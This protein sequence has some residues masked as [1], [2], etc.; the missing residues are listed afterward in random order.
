MA[1]AVDTRVVRMEFDNKQFEKNIKQTNQSL[2]NLKQNLDFDG[3][4][5]SIDK[6][7]LKISALQIVATTFVANIANRITNLAVNLIKSLSVDN[8]SAGWS[9]FGEKT[10]SVATML[11]QKIRIAGQEITD[12]AEKTAIVNE[13]LD[14]LNWFSDETS[15]SFTDMADNVGKFIAAGQDLDTSVKAME[16]IATWAAKAGQNSS[17]ASRAMYQLAQAM[18][19]GKIQKIDWMSIQNANMDTEEFRETILSTAVALGQLTKEGENYVTKTGKKFK[20]AQFADYLSEGWFT[21]E[22]LVKGL[23]KYSAAIDEIYTIATREGITASEVIEKYGDQLDQFGVAAFK[24]AQEAR[25]F[26]DVLNS[27]KDAVSSKWMTTFEYIFGSEAEAVKLWTDLANEL[28]D[29][30]AEGGNFRNDILDIWKELGGREDLFA[31]DGDNQGAFWNIY[32]AIIALKDLIK[33]AWDTVFPLS[34]MEEYSSQAEDIGRKFKGITKTIRE[35]TEEIKLSEE[36]SEKLSKIFQVIFNLLKTGLVMIKAIYY[37]VDPIIVLIK[38]L[39]NQVLNEAL[40]IIKKIESLTYDMESSLVFIRQA[41]IDILEGIDL[42]SAL[43]EVFDSLNKIFKLIIDYKPITRFVEHIKALVK[44]LN[45]TTDLKKDMQSF[46]TLLRNIFSFGSKVLIFVLSILFDILPLLSKLFN[47]ISSIAGYILGIASKLIGIVSDILNG[48]LEGIAFNDGFSKLKTTF[49]KIADTIDAYM[50]PIINAIT[51][52]FGFIYSF[53]KTVVTSLKT[54][55]KNIYEALKKYNIFEMLKKIFDSIVDVIKSFIDSSGK[56]VNKI[57]GGLSDAFKKLF[58]SIVSV[59]KGIIPIVTSLLNVLANL[60]KAIGSLLQKVGNALMNV[61]QGD[62]VETVI[63]IAAALGSLVVIFVFIYNFVWALK[64]LIHPI[65]TMTESI[66]DTFDALARKLN[67]SIIRELANSIIKIAIALALIGSIKVTSLFKALFAIVAITGLIIAVMFAL[68]ELVQP[69]KKLEKTSKTIKEGIVNI[70]DDFRQAKSITNSTSTLTG[71]VKGIQSFANSI[72]KIAI[73]LRLIKDVPAENLATAAGVI[74]LILAAFVAIMLASSKIKDP[75]SIAKVASS[76]SQFVKLSLTFIGIATAIKILSTI[77]WNM[78]LITVGTVVGAI[79]ILYSFFKIM[80]LIFRKKHIDDVVK[81]TAE[82]KKKWYQ[83]AV[84]I[85][86]IALSAILIASSIMILSTALMSFAVVQWES[87]WKAL[88]AIS[89]L[90]VLFSGVVVLISIVSKSSSLKEL[91]M[92]MLAISGAAILL[93]ASIAILATAF[94]AFAIVQWDAMWM[95]M[96]AISILLLIF[97]GIMVLMS[98]I[99]KLNTENLGKT[100]L[101][102]AGSIALMAVSMIILAGAMALF[103]LIEWGSI[104]KALTAISIVS[105]LMVALSLSAAAVAKVNG[106]K[107]LFILMAALALISGILVALA[108]IIPKFNDIE[109]DP[110]KK[111]AVSI[112]ILASMMVVLALLAVLVKKLNI[113]NELKVI[114]AVSVAIMASLIVLSAMVKSF[115]SIEWDTIWKAAISISIL[116][117][118]FTSIIVLAAIIKKLGAIKDLFMTIVALIAFSGAIIIFAYALNT[119]A[120]VKMPSIGKDLLLVAAGF[121]VLLAIA[122]LIPGFAKALL[123]ISASL[124]LTGVGL[125]TIAYG[126][127]A[128]VNSI[129]TVSNMTEMIDSLTALF[130]SLAVLLVE[131]LVAALEVLL[132]KIVELVPKIISLVEKVL[133]SVITL[134][135]EKGPSIIETAFNIIDKFLVEFNKHA[136]SIFANIFSIIMKY[137]DEYNKNIKPLVNK[138]V[139]ILLNILNELKPRI[140][141]IVDALFNVLKEII[142]SVF[143]NTG[144][145][146]QTVADELYK[147]IA[148]VLVVIVEKTVAIAGLVAKV[149]LI[150]LAAAIRITIASLGALGELFIV[151]ISG[152]LLM[153]VNIVSGLHD[154]LLEVFKVIVKEA[155]TALVKTIKTF[156]DIFK[157]VGKLVLKLLLQGL[158]DALMAIGGW[159]IDLWDKVFGTNLR[160]DIEKAADDLGKEAED[161]VNGLSGSVKD[162]Q[163][164]INNASTNIAE[165]VSMTSDSATKAVHNGLDAID[166]AIT[167]TVKDLGDTLYKES[168]NAGENITDGLEDG[169]DKKKLEE[170]IGEKGIADPVTTGT[171]KGLK[172]NSPSKVFKA[173]GE[174]LMDGLALGIKEK[175]DEPADAMSSVIKDSISLANDIIE[176]QNGTDL[177]LTVGMDISGVEAQSSKIKDIMSSINDPSV[178]PAGINADY[179]SAKINKNNRDKGYDSGSQI[180]NSND[181]TYNNTFNIT[182]TDPQQSAE[183]ID[184]MLQR[185]AQMKKLAHGN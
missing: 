145:L 123:L 11:A 69:V 147:F 113:L 85:L 30:F 167:D 14:L 159:F 181:V 83:T 71:V 148:K 101:S 127:T 184:K 150:L 102:V 31:R 55:L 174:F 35:F 87:I 4:G 80:A 119:L 43:S 120:N 41:I 40:Y 91:S 19:K 29:V 49:Q 158:I 136:D 16:G 57:S 103:A 106:Q 165:V 99:I 52:A 131:S 130:K 104:W 75:K 96:T 2:N 17:T 154:V 70:I 81:E 47:I 95:A 94:M 143:A 66:T 42:E 7:S 179:S 135:T 13:Q 27:V 64:T 133:D 15:Y 61:L 6:V 28:Y 33:S 56:I 67:F 156:R 166:D 163:K 34:T 109:W 97:T 9:K 151:F 161:I 48:I 108:A 54:L 115:A 170:E 72:L 79:I 125:I 65:F 118:L 63:G 114:I 20:Q 23:E 137:L 175:S 86:A 3:I 105:V 18:G 180:N 36:V 22:V 110:I 46:F 164:A 140:P 178:T 176:N 76:I 58:E 38:N 134:L 171:N 141:E 8:V 132:N 93:A 24:A 5:D 32:D 138:L 89:I 155:L 124:V 12:L 121:I 26:A 53:L 62:N 1:D 128:L 116:I 153:I 10:T 162:V 139:D 173:I 122:A 92:N 185:Q 126:L 45:E 77:E 112:G 100:M 169:I 50:K 68:K 111:A 146:I 60:F 84:N 88:T 74:V 168:K 107:T 82:S 149:I 172:V 25:T 117:V 90:L 160:K 98:L 37:V 129:N 73:A 39:I 144:D 44:S 51:K 182:S 177:T 152:I 183:E 157:A 78:L 21:S 142:E 59:I